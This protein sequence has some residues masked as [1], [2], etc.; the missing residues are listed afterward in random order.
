MGVTERV[1]L[2]SINEL[3]CNLLNTSCGY[4]KKDNIVPKQKKKPSREQMDEYK[5][6]RQQYQKNT[7]EDKKKRNAYQL[8]WYKN[9]RSV[10]MLKELQNVK[11]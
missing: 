3:E 8:E 1:E 4:K 11:T 9:N 10:K 7:D 6:K 2:L 5:K